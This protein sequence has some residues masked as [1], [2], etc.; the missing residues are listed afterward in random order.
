MSVIY[1]QGRMRI[2]GE[3]CRLLSQITI[4]FDYVD[5]QGV[6]FAELGMVVENTGQ[7][8]MHGELFYPTWT[9]LSATANAGDD[10]VNLQVSTACF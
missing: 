3:D 7:L 4:T 9:R 2:G 1:I 5:G 8:D 10:F 6:N